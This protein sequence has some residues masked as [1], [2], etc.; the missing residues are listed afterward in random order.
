MSAA[1]IRPLDLQQPTLVQALHRIWCAA[2]AQ[3]AALLGLT[4]AQFPPLQTTVADLQASG[5]QFFGAMQGSTLAA[6]AALGDEEDGALRLNALVVS[7][8]FQRRGLGRQLV[9]EALR[10]TAPGRLLRVGT[11]AANQPALALYEGMGFT[12]EARFS[13]GSPPVDV[14]RL[15][16]R[17]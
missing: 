15:T 10:R 12:L 5:W 4:P 9:E 7:P 1:H 14:V 17:A 3:E 2:Y 11:G 16:R 6:A 13:V 8:A